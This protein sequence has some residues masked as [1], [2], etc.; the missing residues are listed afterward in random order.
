[1]H[2]LEMLRYNLDL[3]RRL[4]SVQIHSQLQYPVSFWIDVIGTG[5]ALYTFFGSL[6]L[7]LQRFGDLGGW[8]L[9]EIAF[10][11][12]LLEMSV[13]LMDMIFAGFDPQE[14]LEIVSYAAVEAED[15]DP[16]AHFDAVLYR[17]VPAAPPETTDRQ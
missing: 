13:G 3:Y 11:F 12:G 7:I 8:R 14:Q 17:F 16:S 6:T 15:A 10:L 9:G 1:M 5:I 4:I 2:R